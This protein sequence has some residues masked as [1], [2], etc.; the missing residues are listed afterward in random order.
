MN[1]KKEIEELEKIKRIVERC[2]YRKD[3]NMSVLP[4]FK[5]NIKPENRTEE[6]KQED[7]DAN[8]LSIIRKSYI[9]FTTGVI[10][11]KER[12]YTYYQSVIDYLDKYILNWNEDKKVEDNKEKEIL[13]MNEIIELV[14]R[15]NQRKEKGLNI[16][17]KYRTGIIS[18][19]LSEDE[20]IQGADADKLHGLSS[21][22]TYLYESVKEYLNKNVE[23][24]NQR[25]NYKD[26]NV[27]S[28]NI[29][30][31]NQLN[32]ITNIV[33]RALSREAK[34]V[35]KYPK[36]KVNKLKKESENDELYK[37]RIED[38]TQ[39]ARDY[40][41]LSKMKNKKI[42]LFDNVKDYLDKYLPE[43]NK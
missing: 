11:E 31:D 2:N 13:Q 21:D 12:H 8:K 9:Q 32:D 34:G 14:N 40:D 17:P 16:L 15:C 37:E 28:L 39:Q 36:S 22:K 5:N 19:L 3:N 6:E 30:K 10:K 41:K 26:I 20:K 23:G 29:K 42:E 25:N 33:Q 18:K 27:N 43:W 7:S 38:E 35:N 24:W 4:K 1:N